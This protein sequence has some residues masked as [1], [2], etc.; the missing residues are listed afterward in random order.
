ILL[1][2]LLQLL[3]GFI[4]GV[5]GGEGLSWGESVGA[6]IQDPASQLLT[7]FIISLVPFFEEL[8]WR[9]YA[10]DRLQKQYSPAKASL[11][12]GLIWSIWHLPASFIPG[13]YQA[14]L[15]IGTHEFWLHFIGIVFL[16]IVI[17][18]I[19][20]NT[21]RSIL[22]MVI[23]HATINVSGQLIKLSET[24]ETIFT[25]CWIS[26]ALAILLGLGKEMQLNPKRTRALATSQ[27]GLYVWFIL[28][29]SVLG[30]VLPVSTVT[31]QNLST[32]FQTEIDQIQKDY[33]LPGIT[34]AYILPDGT[35]EMFAAGMSDVEFGIDMRPETRILAASIGKMWIGAAAVK[36]HQENVLDL[37]R[38]I[39]YWLGDRSWFNRLP[40]NEKITIRHLLNHSSGLS[41]HVESKRFQ[42]RLQ[43]DWM[44]MEAA[45]K[46]E[47]LVSY[48]LDQPALFEPGQGWHYTDTGYILA[49]LI[50]EE[51]TGRDI[52]KII[53][54][55]FLDPLELTL[56][57]SSD[58]RELR[59]LASGYLAETNAFGLP[60]KT[61]SE[62]EVMAWHPG[63]E[64]TGGGFISNPGDLV[65]WAK[66]YFEGHA[67]SGDYLTQVLDAVPVHEN[68]QNIRY[69]LGVAIHK[70]GEFGPTYGHG[71]WIPGYCSSLR[72]YPEKGIAVAFQMNTDKGITDS[73]SQTMNEIEIRLAD[74]LINL[75]ADQSINT[76]ES[77]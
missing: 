32:R 74:I 16:S 4:D 31:S 22:V 6:M 54:Q 12:L 56:T 71:G 68:H 3:A 15:G 30:S 18:W 2:F 52:Y 33:E 59:G 45:M 62:P 61:T 51:A 28:A 64:W 5:S 50:I 9:G 40:N 20:I 44:D 47:E 53:E 26:A 75:Q 55:N 70:E 42:S 25:F 39:S 27:K 36:Y 65:K 24:G 57:S 63:V 10:Q 73:S 14:G 41:N 35:L 23:F 7:I 66:L 58:R 29:S 8:G 69:G 72:Y 19:Y 76:S 67:M 60:I 21:N 11:I 38:P 77:Q 37:D 49:G 13:T 46:P 43:E 34:A 1:P 17:S 48:I